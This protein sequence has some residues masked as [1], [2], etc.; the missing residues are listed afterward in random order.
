MTTP[1]L[2]PV[3]RAAMAARAVEAMRV[4]LPDWLADESDPGTVWTED[5]A[6]RFLTLVESINARAA[7]FWPE[8]ASRAGLERLLAKH[9]VTESEMADLTQAQ[10]LELWYDTWYALAQGTPER[11]RQIIRRADPGNEIHDI[12]LVTSPGL[13]RT[14]YYLITDTGE[15]PSDGVLANVNAALNTRRK[16]ANLEYVIGV[17]TVGYHQVRA[18]VRYIGADPQAEIEANL[19]QA[20]DALLRFDQAIYD[21]NLARRMWPAD[22]DPADDTDG[23]QDIAV[24][25]HPS[26][27][28]DGNGERQYANEGV[29]ELPAGVSTVY[30]LEAGPLT[31]QAPG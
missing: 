4:L 13:N 11:D 22:D 12:G 19:G 18:T 31:M 26:T 9:A 16:P 17:P 15:Q 5:T 21:S 28:V 8:T 27:G 10:M 20:I 30:V 3:D 29:A 2:P 6:E 14:T 25:I 1:F 24:T 23:V 7:E